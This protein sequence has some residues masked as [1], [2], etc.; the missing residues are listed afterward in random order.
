[1]MVKKKN[2]CYKNYSLALKFCILKVSLNIGKG[3]ILKSIFLSHLNTGKKIKIVLKLR[4]LLCAWEPVNHF[5]SSTQETL[6]NSDQDQGIDCSLSNE[7]ASQIK[8]KKT[9]FAQ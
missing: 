8:K 2:G 3:N 9:H 1:M 5:N 6:Y 7:S 4:K